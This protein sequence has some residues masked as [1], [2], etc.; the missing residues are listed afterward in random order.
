[1]KKAIVGAALSGFVA[2]AIGAFGAHG[3]GDPQAKAWIVTGSQ[4]HMAHTLAIFVALWVVDKG[5]AFARFAVP[6]FFA[7]IILFAGSLYAL[8]FGAPRGV[9]MLAPIGGLSFMTGW[10]LVAIAGFRLHDGRGQ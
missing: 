4:Q 1:M 10:G 7:G 2:V 3:V 8:A 9:A 5:G 6:L